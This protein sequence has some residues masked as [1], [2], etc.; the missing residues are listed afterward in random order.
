[1][2][3]LLQSVPHRTGGQRDESPRTE[4]ERIGAG[5]IPPD[6]PVRMIH[7]VYVRL[8]EASEQQHLPALDKLMSGLSADLSEY[9]LLLRPIEAEAY[10]DF[11]VLHRG[12][13]MPG[14]ELAAVCAGERYSDHIPHNMAADR[15]MEL[16]SCL[17]LKK[18]RLTLTHS[19]R[20][21]MLQLKVYRAVYPVW[22]PKILH[23]AVLLAVAPVYTSMATQHAG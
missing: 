20:Q 21:S 18:P 16:A 11:L 1:M 19:L 15:L 13:K 23:N 5:D 22:D 8:Q 6:H 2:G 12:A 14:V 10:I 17:A 3:Q 9:C 4:S 7:D